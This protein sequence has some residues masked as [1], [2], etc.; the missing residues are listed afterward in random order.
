MIH[1]GRCSRT[2]IKRST[3]L[4]WLVLGSLGLLF[5]FGVALAGMVYRDMIASAARQTGGEPVPDGA[6][7]EAGLPG[8]A[9]GRRGP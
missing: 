5:V 3:Q 7:R 4:R 1:A 8:A 2:R 6:P 9:R